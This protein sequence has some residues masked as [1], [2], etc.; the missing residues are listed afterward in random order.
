MNNYPVGVQ[1][2]VSLAV[3]SAYCTPCFF[4]DY[5]EATTSSDITLCNGPV[6]FVGAFNSATNLIQLGGFSAV[7]EIRTVTALNTPHLS[8]GIYWYFTS[9]D[10]FGFADSS[11]INQASADT[12]SDPDAFSRMSWHLDLGYGGYRAGTTVNPTPGQIYKVIYNCP[13]KETR[14]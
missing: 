5:S 3:I 10:S 14:H 2:D 6:A 9:G 7:T 8:N 12:A 1:Y 4:V 13:C 11:T